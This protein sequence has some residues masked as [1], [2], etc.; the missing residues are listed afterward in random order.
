V[1][2]TLVERF[3]REVASRLQDA[4]VRRVAVVGD[5]LLLALQ[6][7]GR[8]YELGI[9]LAP[10]AAWCWLQGADARSVLHAEIGALPASELAAPANGLGWRS[11]ATP[12]DALR[13]WIARPGPARESWTRLESARLVAAAARPGDRVLCLDFETED[14][15]GARAR[16]ELR[17]ELFDRG[18][19]LLLREAKGAEIGNW[20]GHAAAAEREAGLASAE[21]EL[22]WDAE[23]GVVFDATRNGPSVSGL[24]A[25]Y[26]AIAGRTAAEFAA[27]ARRSQSREV[28]RLA[29]R[30]EHLDV[31]AGG[32]AEAEEW[33]RQG[34]LLAA[35]QHRVH[36]GQTRITVED[37]FAGGTRRDLDLDPNLSPQENVALFFKRA[38]RGD[39]GRDT[40]EARRTETRTALEAARA[41]LE[42]IP[43]DPDWNAALR[44]ATSA[45]QE[46]SERAQATPLPAL[47][48]PGGPA[49]RDTKRVKE[50]PATAP[51]GPG[52]R[53]VIAGEWELWVG[54][55][56]AENDTLTHRFAH[57]EDVWLHASGVPGS[58]VVLRMRGRTDNPPRE[59][60]EAAAAIAA[61]FSKAKHA[62]TVPVIWTRKRY[63]RKPR[64]SK[65]GL[66][67]CTHEKT[68]FVRPGIP[69]D[70][71]PE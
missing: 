70:A 25:A 24:A 66:A 71:T 32:A 27:A 28:S 19:N 50:T 31:D 41:A 53:F 49:W 6:A 43:A 60:L 55:S 12:L 63:V 8:E 5:G 10:G 56:N 35:N 21:G 16:F 64:G 38:R 48:T 2:A 20:R 57:P 9:A 68:V 59:V 23:R 37:F 7:S 44:L 58:H 40:I 17:A 45:W 67:T 4:I 29:R 47:W 1:H 69:E 62:G 34:E 33:R 39:R 61:R 13:A 14:L 52:R 36:R 15:L 46:T 26:L 51:S 11:R 30:L 18:G 54:R 42:A 22:R 65:P 3:A